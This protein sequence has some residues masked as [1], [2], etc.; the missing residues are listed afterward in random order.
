[1][2]NLLRKKYKRSDWFEGLLWT[3]DNVKQGMI[4]EYITEPVF[5]N[6]KCTYYISRKNPSVWFIIGVSDYMQ[7]YKNNE[8]KI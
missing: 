1:M 2:L 5:W 8:N 6:E 3:E 7:H 4:F